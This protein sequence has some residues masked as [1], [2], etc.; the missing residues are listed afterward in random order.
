M[1]SLLRVDLDFL[2]NYLGYIKIIFGGLGF[3]IYYVSYIMVLLLGL[4][5]YYLLM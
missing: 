3:V 2:K 4:C 1:K 5:I